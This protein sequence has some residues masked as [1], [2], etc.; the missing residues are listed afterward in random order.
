MRDENQYWVF[1]CMTLAGESKCHKQQGDIMKSIVTKLGSVLGALFVAGGAAAAS[2][3]MTISGASFDNYYFGEVCAARQNNGVANAC[4]YDTNLVYGIPKGPSTTGYTITFAG[5][6]ASTS[7]TSSP[8]VFSNSSNGTFLAYSTNNATG[9]SGN[10]S[11]SITF[12]ATQ[13]PAS[14]RLTAFIGLPGNYQ[15]ALYGLSLAY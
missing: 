14:G 2:N 15:G 12:T 11:R 9:V 8:T 7:V 13:A 1:V 5:S 10:W 3:A 6:N 4:A